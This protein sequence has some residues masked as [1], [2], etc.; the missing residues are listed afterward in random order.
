MPLR[1]KVK[2]LPKETKGGRKMTGHR[3]WAQESVV[4]DHRNAW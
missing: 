1:V 2:R 4:T 3:D